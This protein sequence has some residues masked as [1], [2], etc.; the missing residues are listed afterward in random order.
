MP[1]RNRRLGRLKPLD[2]AVALSM[3]RSRYTHVAG[4]I[5]PRRPTVATRRCRSR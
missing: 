4:R 3:S 2:N 1:S 5:R